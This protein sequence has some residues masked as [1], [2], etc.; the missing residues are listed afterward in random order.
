[1]IVDYWILRERE[2]DVPDLY[3]PEGRYRGIN[4]SAVIALIVGVAPNVPG[5]LK[6]THVLTGDNTPFDTLYTYAW[7]VGFAVASSA[8][9]TLERIRRASEGATHRN[10]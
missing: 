8:Y 3:R 7:F 1:M 2:L 10:M 9:L 5:F 4:R 6:S